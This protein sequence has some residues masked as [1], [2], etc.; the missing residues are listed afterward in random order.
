V[1]DWWSDELALVCWF[2]FA[3]V[4]QDVPTLDRLALGVDVFVLILFIC[5]NLQFVLFLGQY[6]VKLHFNLF[7]IQIINKQQ[8][9]LL[10]R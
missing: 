5:F 10:I 1:H 9:F 7:I 2:F 3:E 8:T 6:Q 4:L